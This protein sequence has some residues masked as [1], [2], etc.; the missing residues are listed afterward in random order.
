MIT[1]NLKGG[2]G[3]QL[4]QIAAGY[5]LARKLNTNFVINYNG[6]NF[7]FDK[8]EF[9]KLTSKYHHKLV[10]YRQYKDGL[11]R[12][13]K[14]SNY[15]GFDA[16]NQVGFKFNPIPCKDNTKLVGYFQS[17]KFFFD[18]SQEIKDLFNFS[19]TIRKKIGDKLGK[20][21]KKKLGIH[22]RCYERG[23]AILPPMP[24]VY[25]EI[26]LNQF[27]T[28][29]YDYILITDNQTKAEEKLD[30]ENFFSLNNNDEIEDL[31][32]LSQCDSVIM[33]N[34][35][36]SWWG[37]WLGKKKEKVI[38]PP[39]WFG[40]GGPKDLEDLIPKRWNILD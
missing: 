14:Q 31:Y 26:A 13:I 25:Y 30:K 28:N 29:E 12:N 20:F 11:Y 40:N 2:V 17:E 21:K 24:K 22:I 7:D 18:Y 15:D 39:V 4:F 32:T 16:Y 36:F 3:N 6:N 27:N 9:E 23:F 34:S 35:T 1:S 37:A 19:N 38:V 8:K 5:S 33:S 10:H